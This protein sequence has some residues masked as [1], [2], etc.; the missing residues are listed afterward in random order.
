[1]PSHGETVQDFSGFD[2]DIGVRL[3][4]PQVKIILRLRRDKG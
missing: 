3:F 4:H 1:M 2:H